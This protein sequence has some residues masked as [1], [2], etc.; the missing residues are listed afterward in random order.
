MTQSP[1]SLTLTSPIIAADTAIAPDQYLNSFGCSGRNIRPPLAWRGVP[2]GTKGFALTFYDQ[3][4]PTG[5]GF[6]HWVAY[7]LPAGLRDLGSGPLPDGVVEGNTDFG[8]P[9]YFGPCPPI[10][11]RHRYTFHLHALN[12]AT[13]DIPPNAT[14]ALA[15]FFIFQH[16]LAR[17][18]LTV[19]AGPREG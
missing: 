10:G 7:N 16:T 3:D 5:S 11:R 2:A 19:I 1:E 14:A 8:V 15:G 12:V 17:A 18:A 6:W 4:A 9:G 13:L